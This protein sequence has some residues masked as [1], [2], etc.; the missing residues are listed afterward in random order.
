MVGMP[1]DCQLILDA[2]PRYLSMVCTSSRL[3]S[4]YVPDLHTG[5]GT[6]ESNE[7]DM[8]G[9]QPPR[10]KAPTPQS[11]YT[12]RLLAPFPPQ[13][14][15]AGRTRA[16]GSVL[17]AVAIFCAFCSCER[18]ACEYRGRKGGGQ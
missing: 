8:R 13:C 7:C 12:A 6:H 15:L 16:A 18:C 4:E 14:A 2:S 3:S 10:Q 9:S 11:P 5:P 17:R 1:C